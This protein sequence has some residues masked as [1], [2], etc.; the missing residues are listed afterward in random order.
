MVVGGKD[1]K[2]AKICELS[3]NAITFLVNDQTG[4]TLVDYY[5]EEVTSTRLTPK[6][7][8]FFKAYA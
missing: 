8:K 4:S 3:S 7:L 2:S 6:M 5:P 1:I